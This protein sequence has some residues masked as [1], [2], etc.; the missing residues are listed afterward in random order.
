M[1]LSSL[2]ADRRKWCEKVQCFRLVLRVMWVVLLHSVS[3]DSGFTFTGHLLQSQLSV[4]E[5]VL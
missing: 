1:F 5:S 3:H 2:D 4:D